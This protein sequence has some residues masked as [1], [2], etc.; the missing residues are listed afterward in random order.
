MAHHFHIYD[1]QGIRDTGH[2]L[3][4]AFANVPGFREYYAVKALPNPSILKIMADL[5]FGFDCSSIAELVLARQ[6]GGRGEDIMFT[7]NNTSIEE[8]VAAQEQGGCIL[9]LD[10]IGLIDKVPEM[11]ELVCFRYNPGSARSGNSIIG[12]PEEAKYGLTHTQIFTA[13]SKAQARGAKRFGLHTMLA[14]NECNPAYMVQTTQMLLDLVAEVGQKLNIEFEFINIGGGLGIP[15]RPEDSAFD[16]ELLGRES[17][18]LLQDIC[19][20]ARLP[21]QGVYGKWPLYHRSTW[22]VGD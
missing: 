22:G 15:D 9:N 12:V 2:R 19:R 20:A 17:A 10:D 11:P 5:G 21:A 18:A 16:I 4:Q 14:S 13:F 3:Q 6:A 7:S 1:E 8:F